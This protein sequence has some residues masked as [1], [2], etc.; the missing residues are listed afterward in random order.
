M[1]NIKKAE[2]KNLLYYINQASEQK[3]IIERPN[4]AIEMILYTANPPANSKLVGRGFAK[5]KYPDKWDSGFGIALA[6]RKAAAQI[7]R[8]AKSFNI[9]LSYLV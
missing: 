8:A 9:D 6:Q 1:N 2:K 4:V 5:V 7:I 3:L